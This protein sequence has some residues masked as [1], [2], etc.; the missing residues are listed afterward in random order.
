MRVIILSINYWPEETGIGPFTTHRAEYLAQM[1]HEVTVCTTFPYYPGWKR[2]SAN[3][4]RFAE[5]EERNGVKIHRTRAYIPNP[6]T[7][8]KRILHEISFVAGAFIRALWCPRPDLLFVVSPPLGLGLVAILLSW[9]WGV[10]YV[11]DVMDLQPDTAADLGMLPGWLIQLL[12]KVER[13]AYS[14]AALVS[15]LTGGMRDRILAKGIAAGKVTLFEPQ[16]GN[17]FFEISKSDGQEFRHRYGLGEKFLVCHS[18]NMGVKQGLEV[19]L[20]AAKKCCEDESLEFILAGDGAARKKIEGRAAELELRN[21]RFL[22]V[23]NSADYRGLLAASDIC[24]VTQRRTVSDIVFP[25]KLVTYMSAGCASIASVNPNSE[26]ARA[27]EGSQAGLVIE[28]ENAVALV[29]AIASLRSGPIDECRRNAR[30]FA[31]DRW[32]ADRVL[33]H[34][35]KSLVAASMPE[36]VL[37]ASQHVDQ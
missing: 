20:E 34:L 16:A 35:E 14:H 4:G 28:P 18:G 21:V 8:L 29:E 13:A 17:E 24:L 37:F 33:S 6:V 36:P 26:V 27:I 9:W 7:A 23:L 1:G 12:Y 11:F 10:P 25:S 15:T 31:L 19:I 32:V 3:D 22:P 30:E 2:N 5:S